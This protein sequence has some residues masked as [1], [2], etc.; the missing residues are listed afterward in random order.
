MAGGR[1]LEFKDYIGGADN[2]IVEEMFKGTKKHS[3]MTSTP[4]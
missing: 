3:H 2:V 4:V 1:V